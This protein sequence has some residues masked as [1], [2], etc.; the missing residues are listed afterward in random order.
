[1]LHHRPENRYQKELWLNQ[2]PFAQG[3]DEYGTVHEILRG[4]Q[5]LIRGEAREA[6]QNS[7]NIRLG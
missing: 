5:N 3:L 7:T 2:G 1:M 4:R 6:L